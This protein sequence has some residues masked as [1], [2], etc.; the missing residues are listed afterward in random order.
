[1]TDADKRTKA[2]LEGLDSDITKFAKFN[3]V[4]REGS[5][6]IETLVMN[7]IHI[8]RRDFNVKELASFARKNC[9]LE[10][11]EAIIDLLTT[12]DLNVH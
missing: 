6:Q 2:V 1:M 10:N 4:T 8:I 9:N 3:E 7:S 11:T 5:A 12:K